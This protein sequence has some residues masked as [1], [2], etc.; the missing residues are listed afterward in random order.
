MNSNKY[1]QK[2][3]LNVESENSLIVKLLTFE[4]K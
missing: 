4:N 1:V 3:F 2:P